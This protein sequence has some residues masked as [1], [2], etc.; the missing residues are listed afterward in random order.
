M[1]DVAWCPNNGRSYEILASCGLDH[2]V[3]VWRVT[4]RPHTEEDE[5]DQDN[6]SQEWADPMEGQPL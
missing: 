5:D 6:K 4:V 2:Y 3:M 1:T